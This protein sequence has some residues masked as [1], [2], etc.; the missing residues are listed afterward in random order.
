MRRKIFSILISLLLLAVW[1]EA[2]SLSLKFLGGFTWIKGGDFNGSIRG[3]KDYYRDHNVDPYSFSF[4]LNE[5]KGLGEG[6]I[7]SVHSFSPS[8]SIGVGLEFLKKKLNGEMSWYYHYE[9]D[10]VSAQGVHT[11]G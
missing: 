6:R 8:L 7:E 2:S 3:W 9:E 4:G 11:A 5:L 10:Y 1:S